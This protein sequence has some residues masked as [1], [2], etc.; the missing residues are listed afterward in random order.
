MYFLP[1]RIGFLLS[2]LSSTAKLFTNY[3][4]TMKKFMLIISVIAWLVSLS[5]L[6]IINAECP[7]FQV[8]LNCFFGIITAFI[9]WVVIYQVIDMRES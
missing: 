3:N 7:P 4:Y 1:M 5:T 8:A 2:P 9:T 6:F